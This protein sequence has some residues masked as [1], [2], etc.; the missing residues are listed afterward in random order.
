MGAG[1]IASTWSP[2]RNDLWRRGYQ[3]V[4]TQVAFGSGANIVG[5]FAPE[6]TRLLKREKRPQLNTQH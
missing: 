2:E 1:M 6:I 3:S 4:L 5:E